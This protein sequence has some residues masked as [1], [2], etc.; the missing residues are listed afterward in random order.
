M[1]RPG[2][3]TLFLSM[4]FAG[5]LLPPP[6]FAEP[7]LPEYTPAS[8][9]SGALNSVGSDTLAYLM[10]FWGTDFKKH[11]PDVK[12]SMRQFGSAT[13]LPALLDG[14]ANLAPM[15]RLMTP[16]E[17]R[18]FN[19]KFG[20]DPTE[21]R[22][23]L[24][25]VAVYVNNDN[26]ISKLALPQLDAVFSS[27]PKCGHSHPIETW[28]KA[29]LEG[30]WATRPIA[31]AGRDHMSGTREFFRQ[32]ALCG[33]DYR[34]DIRE[35]AGTAEIHRTLAGN[36][37]A[38]GYSGI[39]SRQAG[40]KVLALAANANAPFVAPIAENIISGKY[41]LARP[42]FIYVNKAPGKP[43]TSLEAEFLKMVLSKAGQQRVITEGFVA[44][45]AAMV[46]REREKL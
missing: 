44:L 20:Y 11:Y 12:F 14:S 40:V 1:K 24:D 45:D 16:E 4:V 8:G 22:V 41:P 26:P 17:I 43:L 31:L 18:A 39:G 29:G 36:K 21:I 35:H 30:D 28:G 34:K 32:K 37:Y 10:A 19:K 42:L 46:A 7:Q 3:V 13:A 6:V 15:S 2:V 5:V 27:V 38:I 9:L 25:A 33:G 23:A